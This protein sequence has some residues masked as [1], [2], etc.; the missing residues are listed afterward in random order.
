MPRLASGTCPALAKP[1]QPPC[2][3]RRERPR[4]RET[5]SG[6]CARWPSGSPTPLLLELRQ[7]LGLETSCAALDASTASTL[8]VRNHGHSHQHPPAARTR[9]PHAAMPQLHRHAPPPRRRHRHHPSASCISSTALT[10]LQ[11]LPA[12]P[13]SPH[14]SLLRH[15]T[16]HITIIEPRCIRRP[17]PRIPE[18][19]ADPVRL[20]L[21]PSVITTRLANAPQL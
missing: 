21:V 3:T 16:A 8:S 7:R 5:A 14:A 11:D 2:P 1:S 19:A 18:Y 4:Q 12:T 20:A 17:C 15:S 6:I 13:R 9:S 10:D